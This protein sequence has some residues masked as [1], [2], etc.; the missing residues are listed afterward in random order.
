MT[1][2]KTKVSLLAFLLMGA[3]GA[4]AQELGMLKDIK[5]GKA[6]SNAAEL[7]T[8]NKELYFRAQDEANGYEL[9][10]S[11]GTEAGTVLVNNIREGALGS[12]P[13]YLTPMDGVVYFRADDG[14]NGIELWKTD[15]HTTQLVKDIYPGA[16]SSSPAY[17]TPVGQYL[18]F[19]ARNEE[20][21]RLWKSNVANNTVEAVAMPRQVADYLAPVAFKGN[22]YFVA[23][24]GELW[25][26]NPLTNEAIA[27]KKINPQGRSDVFNL[28]EA[29]GN[30]YFSADNGTGF[31]LWK[32]D[33]TAAGTQ[34]VKDINPEGSAAPEELTSLAGMLYFKAFDGKESK[35]W[36][37]DG[38]RAGT[39]AVENLFGSVHSL[40][41]QVTKS[42]NRSYFTVD[43]REVWE[44]DGTT[45][46]KLSLPVSSVS[47]LAANNGGDLYLVADGSA[48]TGQEV[49]RWKGETPLENTLAS[50]FELYP[51]PGQGLHTLQMNPGYR[52]IAHVVISG[53]TGSIL[54]KSEYNAAA[55]PALQLNLAHLPSGLYTVGVSLADGTRIYKKLM[56]NK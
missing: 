24:D 4:E 39:Q 43:D 11:D 36:Q 8:I 26:T 5:P 12:D 37:S 32:S 48:R 20:G 45:A 14:R 35:L 10:K 44:T 42:G 27:V 18:Y 17:L 3:F 47:Q 33:G 53:T 38:T 56:I 2:H 28:V 50:Q 51:N 30:L 25:K 6:S 46:R 19:V 13:A 52:G 23:A 31:E 22:L 7:V 9:W 15:G 41:R 40:P 21:V 34:M 16:S 49:W 55:R 29:N 54:F 1:L